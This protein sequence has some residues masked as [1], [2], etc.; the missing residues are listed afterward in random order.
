MRG[1][2]LRKI[3]DTDTNRNDFGGSVH[4]FLPI[5]WHIFGY[6]L[7]FLI[8][9]LT[10][11]FAW[12]SYARSETVSGEIVPS[13]GAARIVPSR[14][15]II[16]QVFVKNGQLVAKGAPLAAVTVEEVVWDGDTGPNKIL[17]ALDAQDGKLQS[18]QDASNNVTEASQARFR[19][20]ELGQR[21][22]LAA[23]DQQIDQQVR[24]IGSAVADFDRSKTIADRGFIS[25]RDIAA[26]EDMVT[27]RRQQLAALQQSRADKSAELNSTLKAAD[28][29]ADQ[30]RVVE[31]QIAGSRAELARQ[32]YE[33]AASRGYT[34]VAP[35]PGRV[36]AIT[37]RIGQPAAPTQS[38]M[39]VVPAGARIQANLYVPTRA[40]GF[41]EVGQV[42]RLQVDA[43][44]FANFGAKGATITDISTV[45]IDHA[46]PEG[47]VE[48]VYLVRCSIP[49]PM[50]T[51]FGRDHPFIP[52]MTLKA[53]IILQKRTLAEWIFEPLYAIVRK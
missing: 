26:R 17:S 1:E 49:S 15:G 35:V 38:L 24:L 14:A 27:M 51:A 36:T 23:L 52:G 32:R 40:A 5:S 43:F 16:S 22:V 29:A 7:L 45:T 33:V 30:Q 31:A 25:R 19:A 41:L 48:P 18:Q 53:Q 39:A 6:S 47:K 2:S 20:Q 3:V 42:V 13:L 10:C 8:I 12:G 11:G 37:A 44:P 34:L 4:L 28:E 21:A 46:N 9:L 50:V